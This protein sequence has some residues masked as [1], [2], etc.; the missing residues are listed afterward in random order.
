MLTSADGSVVVL[1]L[2]H[3]FD[4][5]CKVNGKDNHRMPNGS[6]FSEADLIDQ[7]APG[8]VSVVGSCG[9]QRSHKNFHW[10]TVAMCPE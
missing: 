3:V 1:V 9:P 10:G 5:F 2:V 7:N 6:S 8:Q 4:K